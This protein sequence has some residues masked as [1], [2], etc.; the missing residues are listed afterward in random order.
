MLHTTLVVVHLCRAITTC[1]SGVQLQAK[2][3]EMD[4][5]T[6]RQTKLKERAES[7]SKELE[8]ELDSLRK[9]RA[10]VA[11][12]AKVDNSA[13]LQRLKQALENV[14]EEYEG[15]MDE[16]RQKYRKEVS[17]LNYQLQETES[18]LFDMETQVCLRS[19]AVCPFDLCVRVV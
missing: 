8:A 5:D 19:V 6:S 12:P 18:R 15:Q 1:K 13:E 9:T 14:K 10:S 3:D 2:A 7:Y 11:S 16:A 17:N 4:A